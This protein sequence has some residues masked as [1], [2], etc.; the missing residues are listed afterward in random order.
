MN[1]H[2]KVLNLTYDYNSSTIIANTKTGANA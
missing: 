2:F 1:N